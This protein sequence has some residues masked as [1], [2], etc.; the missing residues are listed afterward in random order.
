MESGIR[1]RVSSVV[2]EWMRRRQDGAGEYSNRHG[3][4]M[5][6]RMRWAPTHRGSRLWQFEDGLPKISVRS[7]VEGPAET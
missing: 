7:V 6:R 3:V 1:S 4:S 5:H 2:D